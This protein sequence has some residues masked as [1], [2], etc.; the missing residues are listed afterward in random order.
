MSKFNEYFKE[1]QL[2]SD[3][4]LVISGE[5]SQKKAAKKFSIYTGEDISMNQL[6]VDVVRFGFPPSCI[7]DYD[8]EDGSC[9]YT[10]ASGK[11][12]KLVWIYKNEIRSAGSRRS[13][14]GTINHGASGMVSNGMQVISGVDGV[15]CT[16]KGQ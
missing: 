7:E 4:T 5:Y 16:E 9:W 6:H 10:G 1:V 8:R 14:D 2:F 3:G 11:G 15:A 12:S 13:Y